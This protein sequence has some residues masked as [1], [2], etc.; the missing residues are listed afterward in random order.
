MPSMKEAKNMLTCQEIIRL[1]ISKGFTKKEIAEKTGLSYMSIHRYTK[2]DKI[3]KV[4]LSKLRRLYIRASAPRFKDLEKFDTADLV[5][6]LKT[7]GWEVT[8]T[9]V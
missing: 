8:L 2:Q 1:L 7:R 4:A 6:A 9:G 3:S 5:R